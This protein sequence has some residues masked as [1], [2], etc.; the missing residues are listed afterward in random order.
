MEKLLLL[1]GFLLAASATSGS[2]LDCLVLEGH[3][4]HPS[5]L[6]RQLDS[7]RDLPPGV[8][9]PQNPQLSS[10][11]NF[12]QAIA[13]SSSQGRLGREGIRSALYARYA[14]G[15]RDLGIYGL[16]VK[17]DADADQRENALREIWAQNGRRDLARVHRK[18]LMLVV[19]WHSGV[20][21]ECWQAVNA[22]LVERLFKEKNDV[23]TERQPNQSLSQRSQAAVADLKRW[24]A[25]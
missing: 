15:E 3:E 7:I 4:L 22:R 25:S 23:Q 12:V 16:E 9:P 21:P 5:L 8:V 18:G 20:S 2:G 14:A 10:D 19:G 6:T 1:L 13:H 17:S 24:A 11:D